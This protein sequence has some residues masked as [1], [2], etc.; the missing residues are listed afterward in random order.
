METD[1]TPAQ[2]A[3]VYQSFEEFWPFYLSQHANPICRGLH[4]TG[5]TLG[6][7]ILLNGLRNGY[8]RSI[9]PALIVG[10]GFS[11]IGH[12][13]F[14]KNRPATFTYPKWSFKSDF[15]MLKLFYTGKLKAELTKFNIT[16]P[17]RA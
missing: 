4:L 7:L 10:Y 3:K 14:E 17:S 16:W 12:F 5:T 9:F 6:I 15:V 2:P 1:T 11:W 8:W 13:F